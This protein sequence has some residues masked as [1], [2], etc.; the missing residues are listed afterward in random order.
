[1][2]FVM[3]S[4]LEWLSKAADD[5]DR[6]FVPMELAHL[7]PEIARLRAE[8]AA[9]DREVKSLTTTELTA[10]LIRTRDD[11]QARGPELSALT[12]G[13]LQW[14]VIENWAPVANG[15]HQQNR[16]LLTRLKAILRRLRDT[17]SEDELENLGVR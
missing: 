2:S 5:E 4:D 3:N 16:R 12:A 9:I 10:D 1:M 11:L 14:A 13:V 15:D 8:D 6:Y 17:F 7:A